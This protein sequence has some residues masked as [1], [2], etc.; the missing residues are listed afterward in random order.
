MH[1]ILAGN[2]LMCHNKRT[3][4]DQDKEKGMLFTMKNLNRTLALVLALLML[5][6]CAFAEGETKTLAETNPVIATMGEREITLAEAQEIAD[7]LLYYGYVENENDYLAAIDYLSETAIIEKHIVEAGYDQYT[8]D[9][10]T[11]FENEADVEWDALIDQYVQYYLTEDTEDARVQ[12]R[13][14]AE[15]YYSSQGLSKADL[16]EELLM[17]EAYARLEEALMADYTVTEDDI[18]AVFNEFGAQYQQMY[19]NNIESYEYSVNY[20][21]YESW[22]KPAGY[23]SV[24][25]ILL[26]ADQELLDNLAAAQ[27]ALDEAASGETVDDAA[28]A[29]AKADVEAARQAILDSKKTVTDEIYAR[30]DKGEDFI[31]LIA[32][33]NTDP[34]MQNPDTLEKG[35]EVHKNSIVYVPDFVAGSFQEHMTQPGTYSTPVV[36]DYGVH[37][38][39]YK[40]DVESGLI[41]TEEI[42]AEI[43]GYLE[44]MYMQT[45]YE[46][47]MKVWGE[48]MELVVDEN[49]LNQVI[50]EAAAAT[51]E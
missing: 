45:A 40:S 7:L 47:G 35:Y 34:G 37:I 27:A 14:Q 21:G 25:H 42:R 13:I 44:S 10:L 1:E 49:V 39:Y 29:A 38:I 41:M 2:G 19:E 16:L 32:E 8:A 22:Y 17:T 9:E 4:S 15:A 26:D 24:L 46:A 28:V 30:I 48:G 18:M 36:S 20:Y 3:M 5:V 51:A 50:A 33:Y 23:R 12:M 11:A 31:S 6:A 43:T